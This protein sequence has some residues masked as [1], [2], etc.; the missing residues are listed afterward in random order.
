MREENGRFASIT[1]DHLGTPTEMYDEMGAPIWKARLD[2][3]GVC[4]IERGTRAQCPFRWPGQYEDEETGL[5][6]N[7]FRY[8]DPSEGVYISQDP[9]RLAGGLALYGYVADPL[10]EFDPYGQSV[11]YWLEQSMRADDRAVPAG[12]AA[13]HIVQR[14]GGGVWGDRARAVLGR[15]LSPPRGAPPHIGAVDH[16]ANG[17]S[18]W[19]THPNQV[20]TVNHPGRGVSGRRPAGYHGGS[21]IHG[22]AAMRRIALILERAERSGMDVE[23]VLR[24]IGARQQAGTWCR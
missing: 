21:G 8:Y 7:R 18:L 17:I 16:A 23:R 2:L 14:E 9:I 19:G 1:T 20:S 6:Y 11:T 3:F 4:T 13:H 22:A 15:K 12:Q 5:Y 10:C 24:Q